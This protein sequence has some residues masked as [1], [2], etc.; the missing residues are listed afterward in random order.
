MNKETYQDYRA[1]RDAENKAR[2]TDPPTNELGHGGA[3]C[4]P[5]HELVDYW[6]G[7]EVKWLCI[8]KSDKFRVFYEEGHYRTYVKCAECGR[9]EDVHTG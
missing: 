2:Q 7:A 6:E 5:D 1:R 4:M 9:Q 3:G 8:C